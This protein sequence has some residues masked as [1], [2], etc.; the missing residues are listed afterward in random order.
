[1]CCDRAEQK[2]SGK[3]CVAD[4]GQS[5]GKE[6]SGSFEC[7]NPCGRLFDC[8]KH[9]CSK[10]SHSQDEEPPHC[11]RSPDV[12]TTC[13]CGKADLKEIMASPRQICGHII[14]CCKKPRLRSLS[15][16]H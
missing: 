12:V 6:W 14:R 1:M 3:T 8:D 5:V 15:C 7:G 10:S 16:Y 2:E 9:L 13:P 4:D 11:P